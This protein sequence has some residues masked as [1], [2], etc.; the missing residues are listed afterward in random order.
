MTVEPDSA[1]Q[2]LPSHP[3]IGIENVAMVHHDRVGA[4]ASFERLGFT[5]T[6]TGRYLLGGDGGLELGLANHHALFPRGGYWEII[7]I[8]DVDRFDVGYGALIERHGVHLAKVTLRL[9]DPA[10]EVARLR[11]VGV[12]VGDPVAMR[13]SLDVNGRT[14]DVD[15]HL[16]AYPDSWDTWLHSS[17]THA[18]RATNYVPELLDHPN[19]AV[20]IEGVVVSS[21]DVAAAIDR[22]EQFTGSSADTTDTGTVVHLADGTRFE[23]WPTD[24]ADDVLPVAWADGVERLR[25]MIL[26]TESL[27]DS[28]AWITER[29]VGLQRNGD[30]FTVPAAEAEGVHLLFE[31]WT[32]GDLSSIR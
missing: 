18:D 31:P 27:E 11:S 9:D 21:S 8:G 15:M 3:P 32:R 22:L 24:V 20:A 17:L 7:T 5:M 30:Q 23:V 25:A 12:E 6:P 2:A 29:G 4:L 13:R 1:A 16:V 10:A 19:G 26:S 14:I 28:A